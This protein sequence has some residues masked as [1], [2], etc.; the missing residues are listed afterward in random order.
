MKTN[1]SRVSE[2]SPWI[3]WI[4]ATA[5]IMSNAVSILYTSERK[6][7]STLLKEQSSEHTRAHNIQTGAMRVGSEVRCPGVRFCCRGPELCKNE[8]RVKTEQ[9]IIKIKEKVSLW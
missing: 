8:K 1:L 4:T 5:D 3:G 2:L 6:E 7:A 9:K